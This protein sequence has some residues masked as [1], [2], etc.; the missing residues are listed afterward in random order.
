MLTES[1]KIASFPL[2]AAGMI[3]GLM[4]EIDLQRLPKVSDAL[5]ELRAAYSRGNEPEQLVNA[6]LKNRH[7]LASH[8]YL[9]TH[10]FRRLLEGSLRVSVQIGAEVRFLP[11]LLYTS[12]S[13]RD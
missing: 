5:L 11:C 7:L 13:P 1:P 2:S 8:D 10:R 6:F 3:D 9:W 12:P 4:R